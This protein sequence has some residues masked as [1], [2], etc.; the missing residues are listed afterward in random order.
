MAKKNMLSLLKE[1]GVK[2][3]LAENSDFSSNDLVYTL[4]ELAVAT[5][6]AKNTSDINE[7][8]VSGVLDYILENGEKTNC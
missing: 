4:K 2:L 1:S 5:G 3:G 8:S 6:C 7:N